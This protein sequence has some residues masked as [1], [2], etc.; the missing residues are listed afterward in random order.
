MGKEIKCCQYASGSD[1]GN[2]SGLFAVEF[3]SFKKEKKCLCT[4]NCFFP[5]TL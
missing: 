5:K 2:I 4:M 3:L 1:F